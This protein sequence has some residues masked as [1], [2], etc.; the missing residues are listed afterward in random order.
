MTPSPINLDGTIK[1][2]TDDMCSYYVL[3]TKKARIIL[4]AIGLAAF[5]LGCYIGTAKTNTRWV[6]ECAKII[7]ENE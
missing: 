2:I 4:G 3:P 1:T 7:G 6:L 5:G